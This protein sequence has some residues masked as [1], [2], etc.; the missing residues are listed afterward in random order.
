[1]KKNLNFEKKVTNGLGLLEVLFLIF[2]VLKLTH[3]ITFSWWF[4]FSPLV[5]EFVI[6]AI[7][8]I[9]FLIIH[10]REDNGLH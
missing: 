6:I 2:L 5:V 4:V 9:V 3:L 1:M 8:L 10:G 7:I